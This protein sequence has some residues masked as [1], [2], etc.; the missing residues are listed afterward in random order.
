[1]ISDNDKSIPDEI[2]GSFSGMLLE[3]LEDIVICDGMLRGFP[4]SRGRQLKPYTKFMMCVDLTYKSQSHL[5]KLI[6]SDEWA[7]LFP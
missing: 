1:M 6:D 3:V 5:H 2:A 4:C 7:M